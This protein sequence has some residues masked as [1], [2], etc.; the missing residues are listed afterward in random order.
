MTITK[1]S[2]PRRRGPRSWAFTRIYWETANCVPVE[3]KGLTYPG[4]TPEEEKR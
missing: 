1:I 2:K 3:G 4:W